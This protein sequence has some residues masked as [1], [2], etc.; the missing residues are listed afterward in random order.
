MGHG[1][2]VQARQPGGSEGHASLASVPRRG[3]LASSCQRHQ[4]VT[5]PLL[6]CLSMPCQGSSNQK[7]PLPRSLPRRQR[8]GQI[9][10]GDRSERIRTY[11]FKEA[12]LPSDPGL[13]G[14]L[15]VSGH[16]RTGIEQPQGQAPR[17]NC[18]SASFF[19][20]APALV[21]PP[22]CPIASAACLAPPLCSATGPHHGPPRGADGARHGR[23]DGR[24][25]AARL[26]RGPAPAGAGGAAGQ[27]ERRGGVRRILHPSCPL[28]RE[29]SGA[30]RC[31]L[32]G[33][34]RWNDLPILS[35]M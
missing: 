27:P 32:F 5:N 16:A 30:Y 11:N 10:T 20:A 18:F 2:L 28:R 7:A 14:F 26:H 3:T 4:S 6:P 8:K 21:V 12:S 31:R 23:D 15:S 34:A 13:V 22:Y 35:L 1:A 9:G 24:G 17:R 29:P 25:Q 19:R 33:A